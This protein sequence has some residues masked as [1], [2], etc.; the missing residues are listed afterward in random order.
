MRRKVL[1]GFFFAALILTLGLKAVQLG[2]FT[3]HPPLDLH[4][5]PALLFFNK[6][7]G[8]EC[9]LR[10]YNNATAQM[11]AWNAPLR[12]IRIDMDRRPDLVQQYDVIRA[13]ALVLLNAES[14]VIWRQDESL[15]DVAPLDL[16][17]VEVLLASD[18]P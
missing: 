17:Q 18:L 2:W 4:G 5:E 13:P 14:E 6:A 10:V 8:C 1:W 9:E 15:N 16:E 7:R 3:S 11:D 12:L